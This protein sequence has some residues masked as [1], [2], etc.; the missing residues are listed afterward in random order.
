M[1]D[2]VLKSGTLSYSYSLNFDKSFS[3]SEFKHIYKLLLNDPRF[4]GYSTIDFSSPGVEDESAGFLTVSSK[5]GKLSLTS[6]TES[7]DVEVRNVFKES[8][9]N[10][11]WTLKDHRDLLN[12][13]KNLLSVNRSLANVSFMK[14]KYVLS[15][16]KPQRVAQSIFNS[17]FTSHSGYSATFMSHIDDADL[18]EAHVHAFMSI[19]NASIASMRNNEEYEE[20]LDKLNSYIVS[21]RYSY[22]SDEGNYLDIEDALIFAE[23]YFSI[24]EIE[25]NNVFSKLEI[26]GIKRKTD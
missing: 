17:E 18:K 16:T 24:A 20:A 23:K 22:D 8:K 19:H 11:I 3:Q 9:K 15:N 14:D 21:K 13:L 26:A 10:L 6:D 2:S 4:N 1:A 7:F 5:D 25:I 12:D